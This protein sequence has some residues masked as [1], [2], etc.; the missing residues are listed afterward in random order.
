[1]RSG[2]MVNALRKARE[3]LPTG[4]NR[5][6]G[7]SNVLMLLNGM[8]RYRHLDFSDGDLDEIERTIHGLDEHPF[9]IPIKISAIRAS[10]LA[11]RPPARA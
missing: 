6:F 5:V 4:E 8:L 2:S 7:L 10:R 1:M 3:D 11:G 9:L